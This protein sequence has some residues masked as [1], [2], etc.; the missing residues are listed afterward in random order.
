MISLNGEKT[1]VPTGSTLLG[2]LEYLGFSERHL[3]AELNME[4]I[5]RERWGDHVLQEGD[6]LELIGF[7][8]GG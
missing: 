4:I 1:E 8:G 5:S 3:V 2:A 7:V 6:Q